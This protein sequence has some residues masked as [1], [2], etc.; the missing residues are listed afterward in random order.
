MAAVGVVTAPAETVNVAEIA[1]A[2]MVTLDGTF[3]AALLELES[4]TT[5][6]PAPAAEE[7]VTVPVP[8]CPLAMLLGLTETLRRLAGGAV[9]VR[10]HDLLNPEYDAAS[11]TAVEALTVPAVMGKVAEVAPAGTVTLA[12]TEAA[13]AFELESR[14]MAPPAG[15]AAVRLTVPVPF[16]PLPIVLGLAAILL[17]EAG[18]GVML[19]KNAGALAEYVAVRVTGVDAFTVPAFTAKV[20]EVAPWGMV[21]L[22]GTLA[23]ALL[24]LE[25]DTATPPAGAAAVSVT[26]AAPDCPLMIVLGLTEKLLIA[27]GGGLTVTPIDL[28]TPEY[29]PVIVAEVA[30]A[31]VPAFTANE[32][33]VAPCAT[34]ILE[35]TPATDGFELES[36]IVAPPDPAAEVRLIEPVAV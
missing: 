5:I 28:L 19:T 8:F 6:P 2:A 21:T 34:V 16:C 30:A 14:T 33:E 27:I 12:G 31:T 13:A 25:S 1:P 26:V 7:T 9:I 36:D 17:R 10:P 4:D 22:E 11:V 18:A 23:A 32:T 20:P 3:A 35:G 24:E 15:A 29:A